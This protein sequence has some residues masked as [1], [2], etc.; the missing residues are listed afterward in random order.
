MQE[1]TKWKISSTLQDLWLDLV[2]FVAFVVAMAPRWTEIPIHEWLGVAF[3]GTII[4]HLLWHWQ[5]IVSTTQ[6]LFG[7]LPSKT[8]INYILNIL[9][10]VDM[11][12]VI[13]SGLFIS[14]VVLHQL[15][16]EVGGN[17]VWRRLHDVS[18][19][20]AILIIGLHLA[21]HWDWMALYLK[22]YFWKP[23]VAVFSRPNTAKPSYGQSESVQ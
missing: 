22:R 23:M 2:L 4:L 16:I 14:E 21:L 13:A 15:G 11:T 6:R 1:K 3:A 5:W 9:L 10:F 12:I 8:R 20:L 19:N 18:S 7:K 17:F